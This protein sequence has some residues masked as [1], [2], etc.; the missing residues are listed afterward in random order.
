MSAR[1]RRRNK[2]ERISATANRINE[3][4]SIEVNKIDVSCFSRFVFRWPTINLYDHSDLFSVLCRRNVGSVTFS[5]LF[6]R[7]SLSL[8]FGLEQTTTA[9]YA[10]TRTRMRTA[11][12]SAV[13]RRQMSSRSDMW[14]RVSL[15]TAVAKKI[16]EVKFVVQPARFRFNV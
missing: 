3:I 10:S 12:L 1:R 14:R 13:N 6:S 2:S 4:Y 11:R 8:L 7:L 15:R 16:Q 9:S 5:L